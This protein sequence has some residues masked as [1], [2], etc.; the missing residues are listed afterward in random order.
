MRRARAAD[1]RRGGPPPYI[2]PPAYDAPHRTLQLAPPPEAAQPPPQTPRG[3][4]SVPGGCSHTLPP[5]RH[6]GGGP[7]AHVGCS[8]PPAVSGPPLHCQTLPRTAAPRHRPVGRGGGRRGPGGHVL[9]D[10][11]RVVVRAQYVP[12]P[13]RH[14]V[15]YVG[16]VSVP[17]TPP[18]TPHGAPASP[19]ALS[20]PRGS[21]RS[22]GKGGGSRGRPPPRRPALYKPGV[23]GR[24]VPNP[25]AHGARFRLRCRGGVGG[26][27]QR[28]CR[29][30][31]A[32][33]SSSSM[34]SLEGPPPGDGQPHPG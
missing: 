28:S 27:R 2:P 26:G 15:R 8:P 22:P 16:G 17:A 18:G 24:G 21:K 30:V 7:M 20:P 4:G 13:Q 1:L 6:R 5:S 19:P 34:E 14:Q 23:E 25:T 9:I 11:T 10:A 33:S 29:D 12:P 32:Y 31:S 3:R